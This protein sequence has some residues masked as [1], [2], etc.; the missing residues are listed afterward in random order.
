LNLELRDLG[1]ES[2]RRFRRIA[3]KE[4]QVLT[5]SIWKYSWLESIAKQNYSYPAIEG[6]CVNTKIW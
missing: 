3:R 2:R 5:D 6:A 4:E 1:F